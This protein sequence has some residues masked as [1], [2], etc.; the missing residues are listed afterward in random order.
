MAEYTFETETTDGTVTITGVNIEEGG[1]E[2]V[3]PSTIDGNP[4]TAIGESAFYRCTGLTSVVIP[5]SVIEIGDHAFEGCTGLTSV[6][7]PSSVTKIRHDAFRG[8]TGLTSVVIPS[9]VTEIDSSAFEGCT[10][11]TSFIVDEKNLDYQSING[12]LCSKDGKTLITC[13]GGLTSVVIPDSVTKIGFNAFSGCTGLTSVVIPSSVTEIGD[14]AFNRCTGLTSVEI[15]SSVTEIGDWAFADCTGLT[16][17]EIPDSVTDI[18]YAAFE[19]CTGLISVEIPSSVTEIDSSAFEGCTGLTSFIVDEKNLDYQSIN[20]LLCSKDGKT[21]ITCPGGLTSVVIP[22]S[23]TKIG[24]NAFSGC[25]GLTSVVIPSSVTEIGD[26]AFNRCTGLTSVEIPS[27]VTEIGDWAFC[28]CTGLTSI[29]IPSS[30]TEIGS[31]AFEGCT[32]LTSVEI[33]DSVT[34]IGESAVM[35][36][37]TFSLWT[38]GYRKY[39]YLQPNDLKAFL[40]S[41]YK[42]SVYGELDWWNILEY[43]PLFSS[44]VLIHDGELRCHKVE[45]SAWDDECEPLF[46]VDIEDVISGRNKQVDVS[47]EEFPSRTGCFVVQISSKKT[48]W[49]CEAQSWRG[50]PDERK[51]KICLM[52]DGMEIVGGA[53]VSD[54]GE[55]K[56]GF[57][58]DGEELELVDELS[59]DVYYENLFLI[60]EGGAEQESVQAEL[61]DLFESWKEA[62]LSKEEVEVQI[63]QW[64]ANLQMSLLN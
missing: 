62:E 4:V 26:F 43:A 22:D 52:E 60:G 25:T 30:V 55:L 23:V 37:Y 35:A 27:S 31:G 59:N 50:V 32:G 44:V 1:T 14:F 12:L 64:L 5:N 29:V 33:P 16:S 46:A 42:S 21:L 56:E 34:K 57:T 58:Y 28:G 45:E 9:S 13:P 3:I 61:E 49:F 7:I 53:L 39:Y 15:P 20:G 18:T 8:C 19:G 63:D 48:S 11:L 40:L 41:A 54:E 36:E 47:I 2:I 24:F 38:S 51:L 17:V 10:G 6:V